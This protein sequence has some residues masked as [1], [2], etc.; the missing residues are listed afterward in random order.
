MTSV[1]VIATTEVFEN[2][3]NVSVVSNSNINFII[4]PKDKR[5]A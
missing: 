4:F 3:Q 5:D 1:A 2:R